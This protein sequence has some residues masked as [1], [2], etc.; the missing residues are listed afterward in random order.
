MYREQVIE[1][2]RIA[3]LFA[4][5]S[6][7][8]S[9]GP[10]SRFVAVEPEGSADIRVIAALSSSGVQRSMISVISGDAPVTLMLKDVFDAGETVT[11]FLLRYDLATLAAS[12]PALTGK[13][14]ADVASVLAPSFGPVGPGSYAVPETIG[15]KMYTANVGSDSSGDI[16]YT[17]MELD[18][19]AIGDGLV[20][21]VHASI[22]CSPGQGPLRVFSREDAGR[23]CLL[24]RDERCEWTRSDQCEAFD[25]IF[26]RPGKTIRAREVPGAGLSLNIGNTEQATCTEVQ[27]RILGE[28]RTFSCPAD[29]GTTVRVSIQNTA[30]GR[31]GFAWAPERTSAPNLL[32]PRPVFA[33][34]ANGVL[35]AI[36]RAGRIDLR[37]LGQASDTL[38]NDGPLRYFFDEGSTPNITLLGA[39]ALESIS[40]D[41]S[42]R[43]VLVSAAAVPY[44]SD[45]DSG[46]S[47]VDDTFFTQPIPI[48]ETVLPPARRRGA[49]T[50]GPGQ[51]LY[52]VIDNGLAVMRVTGSGVVADRETAAGNVT[53]AP[54]DAAQIVA[55]RQ[56]NQ[57]QDRIVVWTN[58]GA[59]YV[60]KPD[61]SLA[62]ASCNA[63]AVLAVIEGPKVFRRPDNAKPFEIELLDLAAAENNG[64]ECNNAPL[65]FVIPPNSEN[66]Q[67]DTLAMDSATYLSD[68]GR[69]SIAYRYGNFGGVLDIDSGYS[70]AAALT[71]PGFSS[72][73]FTQSGSTRFWALFAAQDNELRAFLYPVFEGE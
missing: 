44:V 48:P 32:A 38:L 60:F 14:A 65:R 62:L 57:N 43:H 28:S 61:T 55:V 53:I 3:P 35:Y 33:R 72:A 1:P 47:S 20:F 15:G 73:I 8:V 19:G 46:A 71:G 16:Q 10:E 41:S 67:S 40:T 12:Y 26:G 6:L 68:S 18:P 4:L 59:L 29:G 24:E 13:S 36:E 39:G 50:M 25:E 70:Q 34:G 5:L 7:L 9:C 66:A 23:V 30:R 58:T 54:G 27:D 51:T 49:T 2:Q 11:I 22:A 69:K 42:G 17:E 45:R 31:G 21:K 52:A 64:A 63:G 56:E 37:R